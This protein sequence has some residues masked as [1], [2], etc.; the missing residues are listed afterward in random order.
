MLWHSLVVGYCSPP[1]GMRMGSWQTW[2]FVPV[3]VITYLMH[4]LTP[5]LP[6]ATLQRHSSPPS[7]CQRKVQMPNPFHHI[8][9]FLFVCVFFFFN[10]ILSA[11]SFPNHPQDFIYY[12]ALKNTLNELTFQHCWHLPHLSDKQLKTTN[13]YIRRKEK[14][15]FNM[16]S[17]QVPSLIWF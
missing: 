1:Y 2:V 16:K 14:W 17:W 4:L 15:V 11:F 7:V 3:A 6:C 5:P 8:R 10:E 13:I 12:H 9:M